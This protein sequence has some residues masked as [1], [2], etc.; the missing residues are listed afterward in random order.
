MSFS[1]IFQTFMGAIFILLFA[2]IGFADPK[3]GSSGGSGSTNG[4]LDGGGANGFNF[5][6]IES[7]KIEEK[8]IPQENYIKP[9]LNFL[10]QYGYEVR[11]ISFTDPD[12]SAEFYD[13]Y[14]MNSYRLFIINFLKSKPV[15]NLPVEMADIGSNLHGIPFTTSQ[16][17]VQ[18]A[19]D[20]FLPQKIYN[21]L[22]QK[23]PLEAEKNILHEIFMGMKILMKMDK[24]TQCRYTR[25]EPNSISKSDNCDGESHDFNGSFFISP[26]EHAQV[27]ALTNLVVEKSKDFKDPNKRSEL[28]Y[29]FIKALFENNMQNTFLRVYRSGTEVI[30]A[31]D[32]I[33]IIKGMELLDKNTLFCNHVKGLPEDQLNKLQEEF[34]KA[35]VGKSFSFRSKMKLKLVT[36]DN[37][38]NMQ[39]KLIDQKGKVI[40]NSVVNL[41][42]SIRGYRT[43]KI[44]DK[45]ILSRDNQLVNFTLI[46]N[47]GGRKL[48]DK[49]PGIDLELNKENLKISTY[50]VYE[51]VTYYSENT[52]TSSIQ[53]DILNCT[54]EETI[55]FT[56]Q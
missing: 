35:P 23:D 5:K 40:P 56:K 39:I 3:G 9:F 26:M 12:P 22:I 7:F 31:V 32:L 15:Y 34:E 52:R 8:D 45:N 42:Q 25:V 37:G 20:V 11:D 54:D 46:E 50:R 48:G 30:K 51:S 17:A 16:F 27:R 24:Y 41:N 49:F 44:N 53:N 2:K 18:T 38:N 28:V 13:G 4:T 10:S 19:S 47:M 29:I 1:K 6:L 55:T 21:E 43:S 36:V 33:K 14:N